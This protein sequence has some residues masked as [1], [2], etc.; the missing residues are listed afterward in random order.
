MTFSVV[1]FDRD[2]KSWGV[3]VASKFLAV[4]SVVPWAE[5]GT[6][7][8]ATQALS[9]ISYGPEGL[10]LLRD[11]GAKEVVEKLTVADDKREHRQL[12]IVDSKGEAF[13]FTGS[14]CYDYAGHIIGD[15]YTVQGNILAGREVIEAM[16]REMDGK[17]MFQYRLMNALEAAQANGG[18]KRGKQ[19]SAMLIVREDGGF[20]EFTD[21][22]ID[23]RVDDSADPMGE[24]RRLEFLWEAIFFKDEMVKVERYAQQVNEALSAAGYGTI[25][26]WAFDNN[27][28][29]GAAEGKIGKKALTILIG[30]PIE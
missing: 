23:L 5:A 3:A 24:L 20:E 19:S 2:T 11:R 10:R 18:D 21:R 17:G 22:Y 13:A 16:A 7:A 29:Y 9:N 28:D 1:A 26:E 30:Q 15:G 25:G 4:G 12:G 27:F 6:G 14:K 8:V